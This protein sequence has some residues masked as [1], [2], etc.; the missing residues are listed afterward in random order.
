MAQLPGFPQIGLSQTSVISRDVPDIW[1]RFRLTGYPAIFKNP[2]LAL[3]PAKTVAGT[4][5]VNRIGI[6]PFWQLVHP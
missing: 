4:G 3:V 1:L 5:Y 6:G 2:V